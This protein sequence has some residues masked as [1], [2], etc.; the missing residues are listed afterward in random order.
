LMGAAILCVL[1]FHAS[2]SAPETSVKTTATSAAPYR[3][4]FDYAAF[5]GL[6]DSSA[7][8]YHASNYTAN[9]LRFAALMRTAATCVRSDGRT[10]GASRGP[11]IGDFGCGV[12]YAVSELPAQVPGSDVYG[13]DVSPNSIA[14]AHV[15]G[16]GRICSAP[17]CLKTGSILNIPWPDATF[18]MGVTSDVLEHIHPAD[19]ARAVDELSRVVRHVLFVNV[20]VGSSKRKIPITAEAR[21]QQSALNWLARNPSSGGHGTFELHLSQLPRWWWVQM[22]EQRG[23]SQVELPPTVWKSVLDRAQRHAQKHAAR[24]RSDGR[25]PLQQARACENHHPVPIQN[26]TAY[27]VLVRRPPQK[28]DAGQP[29]SLAGRTE[30]SRRVAECVR[31]HLQD[32]V[33]YR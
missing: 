28:A 15:L 20:A 4:A 9:E 1:A 16:R 25:A 19:V 27:L 8:A 32:T 14:V 18:D 33:S 30:S 3:S 2:A 7:T 24:H 6:L 23:W 29:G 31:S 13:M 5:Y 12:G 10:A 21:R 17:P 22:F 11:R 26:C